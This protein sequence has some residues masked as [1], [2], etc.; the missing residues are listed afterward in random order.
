MLF[1]VLKHVIEYERVCVRKGH[2][3]IGSQAGSPLA[4]TAVIISIR[5]A[6]TMPAYKKQTIV[7][8]TTVDAQQASPAQ[9]QLLEAYEGRGFFNESVVKTLE[10]YLAEQ[11][12]NGSVDIDAD[13]ALLKLYLVYPA[14]ANVEHITSVL[15]KAVAT[16][17]SAFFSGVSS[18]VP[19][20]FRE[21]S[22]NEK[23]LFIPSSQ[24]AHVFRVCH[25]SRM[26]T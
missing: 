9:K 20:S 15:V 7:D 19:E 3:G 6:S 8:Y 10:A 16:L 18:I 17:P 23:R 14:T 13:L 11:L 4:H 24:L 5:T 21:V 1:N 26:T 12:A 2:E 22:G 25:A